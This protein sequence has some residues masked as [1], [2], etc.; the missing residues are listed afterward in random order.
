MGLLMNE[1][2]K[3]SCQQNPA[4]PSGDCSF[5]PLM[6]MSHSHQLSGVSLMLLLKFYTRFYIR[7]VRPWSIVSLFFMSQRSRPLQEASFLL[8]ALQ[9][10]IIQESRPRSQR[11][12]LT[13][14]IVSRELAPPPASVDVSTFFSRFYLSS[15]GNVHPETWS[16][17]FRISRW[18]PALKPC[19][20]RLQV[21]WA[22]SLAGL[23]VSL[24]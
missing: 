4:Q 24:R 20:T 3:G 18:F 1:W 21:Y 22:W 8:F 11:G 23:G 14:V 17:L 19:F 16:S 7:S 5:V 2:R 15:F 9:A 6:W 12:A 10:F 13:N